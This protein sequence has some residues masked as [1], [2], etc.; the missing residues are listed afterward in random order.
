VGSGDISDGVVRAHDVAAAREPMRFR[1]I[2]AKAAGS[3]GPDLGVSDG[4]SFAAHA[5]SPNQRSQEMSSMRAENVADY[6][7]PPAIEPF[8]GLITVRFGGHVIAETRSSYRILE[9]YHPPTYYLP[10]AAFSANVLRPAGGR[11][12]LCEWK[13]Q[14]SYFD[15]ASGGRIAERAGW[16]YRAPAPA[17]SAIIDHIALYAEPMD[18]IRVGGETVIPQPGNFYGGWVTPNITGPVKGAAGT[19]HW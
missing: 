12:T 14:A 8:L 15:L 5:P 13:G 4:F 3:M 16:T 17:Y 9:T 6:P 1:W 19:T 7:R 10:V 2:C 11:S 18:E